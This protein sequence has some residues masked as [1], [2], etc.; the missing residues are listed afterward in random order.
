L[1]NIGRQLEG[2]ERINPFVVNK[3]VTP[4]KEPK[5]IQ[6]TCALDP[7]KFIKKEMKFVTDHYIL[8]VF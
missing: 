1:E 8:P 7:R 3:I 2:Y 5:T 4:W 6:S